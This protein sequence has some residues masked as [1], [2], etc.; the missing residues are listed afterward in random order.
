MDLQRSTL[1]QKRKYVAAHYTSSNGGSNNTSA[2]PQAIIRG[3]YISGSGSPQGKP[4]ELAGGFGLPKYH[5]HSQGV[6]CFL[7]QIF[8]PQS[9]G[10]A[11]P[12]STNNG[13]NSISSKNAQS[14][15]KNFSS[16]HHIILPR[17]DNLAATTR[18]LPGL[19]D[20]QSRIRMTRR[21]CTAISK[22]E[23]SKSFRY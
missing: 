7:N 21:Q 20:S 5:L 1:G 23:H 18:G 4:S 11:T 16:T 14:S 22:P 12:G 6:E 13:G 2:I 8:R 3:G 19:N 17:T 10:T 15:M 9:R